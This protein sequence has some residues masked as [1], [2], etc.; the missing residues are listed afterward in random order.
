M[1]PDDTMPG[2]TVCIH[3]IKPLVNGAVYIA[4]DG[5][6]LHPGCA[7]IIE[8]RRMR[9]VRNESGRSWLVEWLRRFFWGDR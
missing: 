7:T 5:G 1:N 2:P 4:G 3:C 9:A 8:R 6:P